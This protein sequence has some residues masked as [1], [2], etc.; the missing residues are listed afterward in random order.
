M[1]YPFSTP[2]PSLLPR[3]K[4]IQN[5]EIHRNITAMGSAGRDIIAVNTVLLPIIRSSPL[6]VDF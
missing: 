6:L 4:K 3:E 5:G 2:F 1:V